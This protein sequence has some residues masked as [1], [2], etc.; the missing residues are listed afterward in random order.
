MLP[1]Y[2]PSRSLRSSTKN[3]FVEKAINSVRIGDTSLPVAVPK[4]RI[5]L[6]DNIGR[7]EKVKPCKSDLKPTFF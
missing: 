6:P 2:I 4:L 5:V 1:S 3:M 7:I